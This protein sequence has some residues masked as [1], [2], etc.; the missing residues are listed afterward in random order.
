MAWQNPKTDWVT[1]PKNPDETDFNRIE[2]NIAYLIDELDTKLPVG[3]A[4][5]SDVLQGKTFSKTGAIGLTGTMPD[6]GAVNHS[7]PINGTYTIPDGYHNGSGKV[8]QSIA[9]KGAQTY[10]PSTVDQIIASGRYLTG[11]QVIKGDANLVSENIKSGVSIFGTI[12]S[13]AKYLK[14]IQTG[15]L[16]LKAST[17]N[18]YLPINTIDASKSIIFVSACPDPSA[19]SNAHLNDV[20]AILYDTEILF[21]RGTGS[22]E[23]GPFLSWTVLEFGDVKSKQTGSTNS[24][25]YDRIV[26]INSVNVAKTLVFAT[27][28]WKTGVSTSAQMSYNAC[29]L[30]SP[31]Q[32]HIKTTGAGT[33]VTHVTH[34]WQVLELN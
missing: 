12:G 17:T 13:L 27:C 7:L 29:W 21:S 16:D 34:Y 28:S 1:N 25:G 32:L 4:D 8:T 2:G 9:T 10:I 33:S 3:N 26:T 6:R 18:Y 14:S 11:N 31:T 30:S 22:T 5:P 23:S 24:G 15:Y 20:A 19:S